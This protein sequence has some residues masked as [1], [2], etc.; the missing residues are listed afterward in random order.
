MRK[1]IQ[2]GFTLIELMIVIAIIG[3]L[4][5]IALP[6]YQNYTI[7]AQVTEGL[8]L[9]SGVK[10]AIADYYAANGSYPAAGVTTATASSGLGFTNK[11]Q[12]KYGT[13]DIGAGGIITITYDQAQANASLTGKIL[14][15][16]AGT[17]GN[18]DLIWVCGV[19]KPPSAGTGY[20]GTSGSTTIS[21]LQ[22]LPSSCK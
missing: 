21:N 11:P 20:T 19:A 1:N 8:S 17:S 5:A 4:A 3:I 22:W 7:R 2:K 14:A 9:A 15:I 12:G 16:Y 10:T 6:A 13:A 18:G